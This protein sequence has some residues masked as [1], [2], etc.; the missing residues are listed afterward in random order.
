MLEKRYSVKND[1][2]RKRPKH[3]VA[4]CDYYYYF[5]HVFRYDRILNTIHKYRRNKRKRVLRF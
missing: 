4:I 1:E 2:P 3:I 5:K